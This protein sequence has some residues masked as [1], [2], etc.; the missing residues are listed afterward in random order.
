MCSPDFGTHRGS[1]TSRFIKMGDWTGVIL[2]AGQ[3]TRMRSQVPKALHTV[4]GVTLVAHVAGAMREAGA[5]DVI[6]VVSPSMREMP[7]LVD[8]PGTDVRIAVQE[9]PLGT[10]HA[11]ESA[12]DAAGQASTLV[13][14]AGDMALVRPE[15]ISNLVRQHESDRSLLS[16]L[17][18]IV[19][20]PYGFGR[21][22][23]N[24]S[25]KLTAVVEEA[26]AD[27][28][29]KAI[30]EI[31]TGLYCLDA[32]WAWDELGKVRVSAV[33]EKYLPDLIAVAA[34]QERASA[35]TVADSTEALGVNNRVQLAEVEQVMRGRIRER[36]MMAGVTVRDPETTY[37]DADV[38]IGQ[39]TELLPGNH[40]MASTRIGANCVIG[41]NSVLKDA[42]IRDGAKIISSHIESAEVG[43]GVSV[44]PFSRIR[45]GT[46]IESGAYVG[47]YAEIKNSRIGAGTHVGHFSYTGDAELGRDVNI[48]AG[49]VTA[50]F[51][52]KDKHRTTIGDRAKIGSDTVMVAPV[53]VG[54]DASTGAGSVV[55]RDVPAGESYVGVPAKPIKKKKKSNGE[56]RE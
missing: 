21:V 47:N 18:A 6:A 12:R 2:A 4:C 48:G 46:Y 30:C 24:S 15:S 35:T 26:E 1:C 11:L 38:E 43:A 31:N 52:G 16:M 23:R 42:V 41:P 9:E 54:E 50:N 39:D 56:T 37:I 27:A 55:N 44:G 14:G 22:V 10:A 53:T 28:A 3:G 40:I 20:E 33:G 7:E 36:H 13:V 17:T 34:E 8:V 19:E 32:A 51:D 49:S 5:S 45:A 29:Q 25:G